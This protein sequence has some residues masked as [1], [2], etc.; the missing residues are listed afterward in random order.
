MNQ[1]IYTTGTTNN[2]T[3][4]EF[5]E[6]VEVGGET[7]YHNYT[8]ETMSQV[9]DEYYDEDYSPEV[10]Y[11]PP[12][13]RSR[14]TP[15]PTPIESRPGRAP[16]VADNQLSEVE[17]E[18]RNRRRARNREAAARQRNRRIE[19][20]DKLESEVA[21]LRLEQSALKQENE[22]L[23]AEIESLRFRMQMPKKTRPAPVKIEKGPVCSIPEELF[24]PSGTFVLQTPAELKS[25]AFFPMDTKAVPEEFIKESKNYLRSNSVSE[26]FLNFL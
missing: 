13:K 19:K 11:K 8:P 26:Q 22:E 16:K 21:E 4:D 23:K 7:N 10:E 9:S 20:V 6:L 12:A 24:T 25:D 1:M 3:T 5:F 14:Y 15:K 2:T 17:L 18:R